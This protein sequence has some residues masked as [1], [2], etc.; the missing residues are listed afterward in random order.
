[1]HT[2]NTDQDTMSL[3]D[4]TVKSIDGTDYDMS[5]L[6]GKKVMVVNVA[7]E[8]GLTP[9]Y[10]NLQELYDNFGG[11]KFEIIAFPANNFGAQEPGTNE[12][13]KGFCTKNYGVTFPV[14]SKISV[15]GDDQHPVYQFLTQKSK[16]G[17][18]DHEMLWNF[19]KFLIDE[20]GNLVKNVHPQTLPID[21][22]IIN[23]I[24]G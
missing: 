24:S 8:C 23:W 6:S 19:Q 16:N 14:M 18:G 1:M 2:I 5:Q 13:I 11:E 7:S 12:E 21:E 4:F 9:Q 17:L 15:M 3:H 10:A 20:N 22:S